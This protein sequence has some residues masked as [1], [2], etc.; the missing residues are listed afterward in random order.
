MYYSYNTSHGKIDTF[1]SYSDYNNSVSIHFRD[2][3][4]METKLL[5]D[6]AGVEYF[7]YKGEKIPFNSFIRHTMEE[8]KQRYENNKD[9]SESEIMIAIICDGMDNVRF[10]AD[11][12]VPDM[13]IPELAFAICSNKTAR[14]TCK[15]VEDY[16]SMPHEK[17]KIKI[18]VAEEDP[19]YGSTCSNRYYTSS[20]EGMLMNGTVEILDSIEDGKSTDE[21]INEY[22]KK[23]ARK[24]RMEMA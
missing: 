19:N 5:K 9:V 12:P 11:M 15:L 22:F 13:V 16:I 14:C 18:T 4:P 21:H 3:S 7:K 8:L 10:S 24:D 1:I 23:V 6:E 2:K 17:Y 20:F